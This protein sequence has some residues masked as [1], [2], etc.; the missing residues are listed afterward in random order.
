MK[1]KIGWIC[2]KLLLVGGCHIQVLNL[3]VVTGTVLY[4]FL[5]PWLLL[6]PCLTDVFGS[7][8]IDNIRLLQAG[9]IEN[10]IVK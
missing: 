6:K 7:R 5:I 8:W 3:H 4:C 2:V 10:L 9:Y 1:I